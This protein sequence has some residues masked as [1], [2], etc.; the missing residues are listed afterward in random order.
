[1]FEIDTQTLQTLL[2]AEVEGTLP[3]SVR[4]VGTDTRA[5]APGAL[6]V[7]LRGER[8]DGHD[9]ARQAVAGG[10]ALVIAERP[11]A[12]PH[13]RVAD[14]LEAYQTLARWWRDRCTL[15]VVAVTGSAG[16]TTTREL[17]RAVLATA[18]PV[19][20]PPGNENN[21]VGVPKL[22]LQLTD[23]YRYCVVEMGMRGPGEIARLARCAAPNVGVIT[24][25]G[26]AHIG[27]LGSHAAIA[28]AKCELLAELPC[29][30]IAVLNGEDERLLSTARRHWAGP[31][32]TYGLDAGDVMGSFDG[33][34]LHVDGIAFIPPLP[35]RHN[36]LNFL[37]ALAV[38]RHLGLDLLQVRER[39]QDLYLPTGRSLVIALEGDVQLIDE[40]YNSAPE[41]ARAAL[42]WFAGLPGRR[43]IAVL[44]QMRELGEFSRNLHRA[45]GENCRRLALDEVVVLEAGEDT[46]ALVAGAGSLPVVQLVSHR[47]VAEYLAERVQPGDRL[48]F[49]AS[50]AVGLERVLAEFQDLFRAGTPSE[51]A[52]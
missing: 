7:A 42:V 4:G 20:A 14:T 6:F 19:L 25:V 1:M 12:V 35:G 37:A 16:K 48:L 31:V 45:L 17:I 41:S 38:A 33:V 3:M 29:S 11:V 39:L 49:K 27:R 5:L 8:F 2:G 30:G 28:D 21:D 9:Y 15:P 22:L 34:H 52:Q 50:R 26:S 43:R 18:G 13:L 32:L 36:H 40:T 44:G 46:E 23:A 47:A 24:N 10:A 51:R